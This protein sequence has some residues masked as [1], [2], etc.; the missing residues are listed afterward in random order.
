MLSVSYSN[1]TFI[2]FHVPDLQCD[3]Y[4]IELKL[5]QLLARI[6]WYIVHVG[7][8]ALFLL[9]YFRLILCQSIKTSLWSCTSVK[10]A[11]TFKSPGNSDNCLRADISYF[12]CCMRKRDVCV[13]PSLIVFQRP[14]GFPRSWE[15]AVIGWHTVCIVW[16]NAD[17]LL[18]NLVW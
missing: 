14:A 10:S 11:E 7:W 1:F 5:K 12:L 3:V 16:H 8:H 15:H 13:T 6:A 18:S 9:Y 2:M 4:S 17:W